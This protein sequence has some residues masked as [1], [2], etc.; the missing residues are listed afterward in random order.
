MSQ[1][2]YDSVKAVFELREA[3]LEHGKA[4]AM[5]ERDASH[6]TRDEVLSTKV[7]LEEKTAAAIDECAENAEEA[8]EGPRPES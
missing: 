2:E 8:S 1:P 3:A 5:L 4:L 7:A 6:E